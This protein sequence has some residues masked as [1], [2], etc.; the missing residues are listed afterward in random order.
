MLPSFIGDDCHDAPTDVSSWVKGD[1]EVVR[2]LNAGEDVDLLIINFISHL[3]PENLLEGWRK[4]VHDHIQGG[5]TFKELF[6]ELL[7]RNC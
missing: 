6:A 3:Q 1:V 4:T 7:F 5:R 2:V